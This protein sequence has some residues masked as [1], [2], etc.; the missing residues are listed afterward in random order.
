MTPIR[1][2]RAGPHRP[3]APVWGLMSVLAA[4]GAPT[5]AQER[6]ERAVA[7]VL[8][9]LANSFAKF[10]WEAEHPNIKRAIVNVWNSNGWNDEADRFAR[11]LASE[12]SAIPPWRLTARL[13][14]VTDRVAGRYDFSPDQRSRFQGA[15]LREAGELLVRHGATI[16]AHSKEA[17]QTRASGKPFTAE[18]VARWAK[19]G[20]P[21][22]SDMRNSA[23]RF[24]A[25]LEPTLTPQQREV[26][27][28]DQ[29][30]YKKRLHRLNE[31]VSAWA[32]GKWQ[33]A[34]WG[35]QD[36][37]IQ[38]RGR[39]PMN[40]FEL[41]REA[42]PSWTGASASRG[43]V[44]IPR[45]LDYDPT[46]WFAYVLEVEKRYRL[47]AAQMGTAESIHAELLERAS[48]TEIRSIACS[49]SWVR[50]SR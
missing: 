44:V 15:L 18:Q 9:P 20:E 43:K 21:L 1:R 24:I 13:D 50:T 16:L 25:Q 11:E 36:D 48:S 35:L 42:A 38:S 29:A 37:P 45:W 40:P 32:S 26:L 22:L 12:V 14:L 31:T 3:C 17:F 23:E 41:I 7:E 5:V 46:T 10:D 8:E 19:Q 39:A 6:S 27:K 33:P 47:D 34:D 30:S 49:T 4:A 28:R 2:P